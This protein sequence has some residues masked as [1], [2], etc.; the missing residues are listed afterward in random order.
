[1]SN[2]LKVGIFST[3]VLVLLGVL[4]LRIEDLDLFGGE[5]RHLFARFDTVAGLDDK[6]TVRIAGVRVGRVD[7]IELDGLSAKVRLMLENPIVLTEGTRARIANMGMLGDKYVILIPGPDQAAVLPDGAVIPGTTP[8]TFDEAMDKL[9]EIGDSVKGLMGGINGGDGSSAIG[10]LIANLEAVSGDIRIM[11]ATNRDEIDATLANARSFSGTLAVELPKIAEQV[12]RVL[13]Q[14]ER[15]VAQIEGA[16]GENRPE[17]RASLENLRRLSESAQVSVQNINELTGKINTGE[18][19]IGKLVNSSELHDNLVSTLDSVQGGVETLSNTLGR[20]EKVRLELGLESF[21]LTEPGEAQSSFRLD[22]DP[23]SGRFYRLALVESPTGKETV[24]TE[25]VTVT[26]PDGTTETT[27]RDI[28]KT[29][30]KAT[31]SALFGFR[32]LGDARVMAGLIEG[33]GG[34]QVEYPLSDGRYWLSLEAFD[35]DRPAD[36][37]PHLR[38]TGKWYLSPNAYLVGGY[39]DP[40]VDGKR[41]FFLG[42]GVRWEDDDLK[43][44]M[45]SIPKF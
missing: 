16:V 24:K 33:T 11:V 10:R 34:V 32:P 15:A 39:D 45:G 41:S 8:P 31:I 37:D 5:K 43:Y 3:I 28:L 40:L 25:E 38:L 27:R 23:K 44:L 36:L 13:D 4:I 19:T 42:G 17:L 6:A 20:I 2:A 7:G 29:E 30:E 14:T 18:G 26:N 12:R 21:Y 1:M 9:S 35:F 22:L